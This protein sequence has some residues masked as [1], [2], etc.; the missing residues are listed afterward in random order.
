[1][2]EIGFN[3]LTVLFGF[4]GFIFGIVTLFR[5][6]K[7][8]DKT[9][10]H[11]DGVLFTEIGYIKAG[12]DDVKRDTRDFR[13]EIKDLRDHIT[14]TEESCKQAHKRIDKLEKYHQPN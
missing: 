7:S 1:M 2:S 8:D 9:E 3:I 12:I 4:A 10:G 14:R 6:K 13:N 5:N 11:Q